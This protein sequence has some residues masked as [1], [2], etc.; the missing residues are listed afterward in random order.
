MSLVHRCDDCQSPEREA[1]RA[2]LNTGKYVS[3]PAGGTGGYDHVVVDLCLSC[4]L[5]RLA[6]AVDALYIG[7]G[8]VGR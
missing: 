3:D 4:A 8:V 2:M 1:Q 7:H 6:D 5:I